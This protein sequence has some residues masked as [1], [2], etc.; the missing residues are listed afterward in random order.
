[1]KIKFSVWGGE[2]VIGFRYAFSLGLFSRDSEWQRDSEWIG[3][4]GY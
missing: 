1:M 4:S 2:T 3:G